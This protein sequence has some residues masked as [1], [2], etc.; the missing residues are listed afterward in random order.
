[1]IASNITNIS[2]PCTGDTCDPEHSEDDTGCAHQTFKCLDQISCTLDYCE[3]GE[4][5]HNITSCDDE[6]A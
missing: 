1:M 3:D 4:C 6:I 2:D 5:K